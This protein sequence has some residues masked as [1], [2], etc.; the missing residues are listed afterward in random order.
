MKRFFQILAITLALAAAVQ[1]VQ[2]MA[3]SDGRG[4]EA[5]DH[6]PGV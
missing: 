6:E 5:A 3:S 1:T 2:A 4:G